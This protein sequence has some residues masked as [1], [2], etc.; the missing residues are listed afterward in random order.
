MMDNSTPAAAETVDGLVAEIM[1]MHRCLP[2][3]PGIEEL[4]AAK[5]LIR[6]VERDEQQKL[7]AIAKQTKGKRVPEELFFVY[8]EMQRRLI[9]FQCKEQKREAFHLLDLENAHQVFDDLIQ[10]ASQ[11]VSP[12]SGSGQSSSKV[13]EREFV[14]GANGSGLKSRDLDSLGASSTSF[15]FEKVPPKS[16]S[17][18]FTRD[19]SY[20]KNAKGTFHLDGFGSQSAAPQILDST[21]KAATASG[22][23]VSLGSFCCLCSLSFVQF[24]W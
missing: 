20:V 18:L 9:Q 15:Y 19:D 12:G 23:I 8:Q 2:P 5:T 7:E 11:C 6:N 4:E 22:E 3:R 24:D 13:K 14:S 17:E 10:R 1:R 21:I 16:S